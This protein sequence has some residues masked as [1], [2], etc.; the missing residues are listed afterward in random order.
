[1]ETEARK[2]QARGFKSEESD[3][4]LAVETPKWVLP[5]VIVRTNSA[6]VH[7]GY[8]RERSGTEVTLVEAR[9]IW[10]WRGANT[11]H[12]LALRGCDQAYSRI[13]EAVP[14]ITL[15]EGIEVVPCSP[16]AQDNL[17]ESRWPA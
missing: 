16:M 7:C 2:R 1:M 3:Q 8:L 15:T 4:V 10:R 17:S 5:F 14:E 13:S 11:I 6:G 12:E 9:R